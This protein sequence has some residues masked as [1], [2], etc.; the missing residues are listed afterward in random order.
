[1]IFSLSFSVLFSLVPPDRSNVARSWRSW[2]FA[3]GF[4][5]LV[6]VELSRFLG[7]CAHRVPTCV[8]RQCQPVLWTVVRFAISYRPNAHAGDSKRFLLRCGDVHGDD[9]CV[10]L[11]CGGGGGGGVV[12]CCC[13]FQQW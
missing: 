5:V 2:P 10:R 13:M 8:P 3:T 6:V 12:P 9:A 4:C 1:M 7:Q 11:L